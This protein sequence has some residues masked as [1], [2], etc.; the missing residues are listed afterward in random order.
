MTLPLRLVF[1]FSFVLA[2]LAF[3]S[4]ASAQTCDE[5]RARLAGYEAQ[6][7]QLGEDE[8][9]V[10]TARTMN[11]NLLAYNM[12][13]YED[14]AKATSNPNDKHRSQLIVIYLRQLIKAYDQGVVGP[15]NVDLLARTMR[16]RS[17]VSA[18]VRQTRA[19][20]RTVGCS[21]TASTVAAPV[22][23]M[24]TSASGCVGYSGVWNTNWGVVTFNGSAGSYVFRGINS[25]LSGTIQGRTYRGQYHQPGYPDPEYVNGEVTFTLSADGNS[26]AGESWNRSKTIMYPWSGTCAG[27]AQ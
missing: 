5:R 26:W 15:S 14:R 25:S 4:A 19:S 6:D 2:G 12:H 18:S 3:A 9:L 1:A 10:R 22:D 17:R 27:P 11:P 21:L 13:Q 23:P 20:M 8:T 7:R 16:D 24:G